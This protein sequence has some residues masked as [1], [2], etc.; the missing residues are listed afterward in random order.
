MMQRWREKIYTTF[1]GAINDR[2]EY[3][4]QEIDKELAF[5]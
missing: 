4:K 5:A 3:Q 1:I 2:D